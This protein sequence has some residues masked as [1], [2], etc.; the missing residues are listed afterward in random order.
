MCLALKLRDISLL[1]N[2]SDPVTVLWFRRENWAVRCLFFLCLC[3][4]FEHVPC[5][6]LQ[7]DG[8]VWNALC[9]VE[10]RNAW[11]NS[12]DQTVAPKQ[13][14][15]SR[16]IP[17]TQPRNSEL[18]HTHTRTHAHTHARTH[19]R[20]HTHTHTHTHTQRESFGK[21]LGKHC[22]YKKSHYCHGQ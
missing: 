5:V 10:P 11:P 14:S 16:G 15:E 7:W 22:S 3:E 21:Y 20:T 19:A 13:Y 1:E 17:N 6:V 9:A 18:T 12:S 4:R 2:R 8:A